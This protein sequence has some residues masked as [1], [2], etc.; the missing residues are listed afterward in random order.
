MDYLSQ[1]WR[2][3]GWNVS[4]LGRLALL[5]RS[6]NWDDSRP[7]VLIDA[8]ADSP[9]F[10]VQ[11][12]KDGLT[13]VAIPLGGPAFPS[14]KRT[15][16]VVVDTAHGSV[17]GVLRRERVPKQTGPHAWKYTLLT[18]TKVERADR[19]CWAGTPEQ[20][21][22]EIRAPFLDNRVGCF[23]LAEVA[24]TLRDSH[25]NVLLAATT[26]EE[27]LGFG[28]NAVAHNTRPDFVIAL[29]TTYAD[30]E[31]GVR[32]GAGP[33]L[34]MSDKSVCLSR[35]QWHALRALCRKWNVPL[36][37]E[38]YNFAGTD[39]GAFPKAG[40]LCP[41]L[42]ILIATDGNHSP[43]ETASLSDIQALHTLLLSLLNDPTSLPKLT[44]PF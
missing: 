10:S 42:P 27:F 13:S 43:L 7:T 25:C 41:T 14:K 3:A 40:L 32:R 39:A 19:V 1:A 11:S 34:T 16:P 5:A 8:H 17:P 9:G 33:V 12:T 24:R 44:K 28:A 21:K 20:D 35:A 4:V 36:Q 38:I 2:S 23:L 26:N 6:P 37:N 15:V 22:N 18:R 30:Q 29:D 31:Q